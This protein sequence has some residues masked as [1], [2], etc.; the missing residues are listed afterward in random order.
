MHYLI[1]SYISQ[2]NYSLISKVPL[3]KTTKAFIHAAAQHS[4]YDYDL[5]EKYCWLT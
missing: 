5:S 1:N 3:L 2:L 4:T